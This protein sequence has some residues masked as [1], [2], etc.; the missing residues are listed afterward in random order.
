MESGS[1]L[2]AAESMFLV[3][4]DDIYFEWVCVVMPKWGIQ[5]LNCYVNDLDLNIELP[6]E[7]L[8][9]EKEK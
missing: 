6:R 1:P 7:K 9:Q 5:T 8:Y 4:C 2:R 3:W